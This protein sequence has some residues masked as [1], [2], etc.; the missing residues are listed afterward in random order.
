VLRLASLLWRLRRA[1]AIESGL[2][3][4]QARQLL[5]FSATTRG[6]QQRQKIIDSIYRNAVAGRVDA[7][8][9]ENQHEVG[10]ASINDPAG[11]FDDLTRAYVRL[12]NLSTCPL[13]RLSRYEATLW[14]QACQILFTLQ[15]LDRRKPWEGLRLRAAGDRLP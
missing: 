8:Q 14:R 3:R 13:D 15:C 1:T 7:G 4:Q 9:G 5:K 6:H 12:S 11:Q 2:F 10:R